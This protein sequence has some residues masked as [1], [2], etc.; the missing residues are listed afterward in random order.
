[1]ASWADN[2]KGARRIQEEEEARQIAATAALA[3]AGRAREL[4]AA[5]AAAAA[6]SWR[7]VEVAMAAAAAAA[8]DKTDAETSTSQLWSS[9]PV[10]SST[11]NSSGGWP[12]NLGLTATVEDAKNVAEVQGTSVFLRHKINSIFGDKWE[13]TAV[14]FRSTCR[15]NDIVLRDTT[16][17]DAYEAQGHNT[18]AIEWKVDQKWAII[19]N[20]P[21]D[22][23]ASDMWFA[24][25]TTPSTMA[26]LAPAKGW[27]TF[28]CCNERFAAAAAA[29]KAASLQA[30]HV[31]EVARVKAADAEA[32]AVEA[33]RNAEAFTTSTSMH[34]SNK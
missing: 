2:D 14:A 21:L 4:A 20:T 26:W 5:A 27:V 22:T 1:M 18:F 11:G 8:A 33:K 16:L 17:A 34:T 32:A 6:E 19:R 10:D 3:A 29:T 13:D 30:Q 23:T 28:T 24:S 12:V 9:F 31:A 15:G 25:T 7:N